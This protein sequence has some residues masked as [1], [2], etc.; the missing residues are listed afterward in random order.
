MLVHQIVG[1]SK[2]HFS[3]FVHRII[4]EHWINWNQ[5]VLILIL[6]SLKVFN[7]VFGKQNMACPNVN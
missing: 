4:S 5:Y 1:A 7:K 6:S 2:E 3:I